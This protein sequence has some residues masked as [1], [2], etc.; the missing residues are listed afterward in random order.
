MPATTARAASIVAFQRQPVGLV[1]YSDERDDIAK[2]F[3]LSDVAPAR[4][5]GGFVHYALLLSGLDQCDFG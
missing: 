1:D 3:C 5:T 2:F 4:A